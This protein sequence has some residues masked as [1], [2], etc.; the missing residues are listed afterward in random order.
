MII[1]V[2]VIIITNIREIFLVLVFFFLLMR[3]QHE[4]PLRSVLQCRI[5]AYPVNFKANS[6]QGKW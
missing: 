1:I 5:L 2:A 3:S 4:K 6:Y